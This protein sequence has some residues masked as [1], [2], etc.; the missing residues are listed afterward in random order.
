MPNALAKV[1][2]IAVV[3][4][5][6]LKIAQFLVQPAQSVSEASRDESVVTVP[7]FGEAVVDRRDGLSVFSQP[8][9]GEATASL[10]YQFNVTVVH[11]CCRSLPLLTED[12]RPLKL[13]APVR[14]GSK[15]HRG[16]SDDILETSR[17]TDV[18]GSFELCVSC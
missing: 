16:R 6:T 8:D 10:G 18:Q 15:M 1:S 2:A 5:G 14:H 12:N 3:H 4:G 7:R 17:L 13:S 9:V 11:V